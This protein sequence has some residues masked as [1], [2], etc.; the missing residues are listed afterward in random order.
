MYINLQSQIYCKFAYI[1]LFFIVQKYYIYFWLLPRA[2]FLCVML[3]K[4]NKEVPWMLALFI[5]HNNKAH[6][7]VCSSLLGDNRDIQY[8]LKDSFSHIY[9]TA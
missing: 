8:L 1:L 4:M 3:Q 7:I 5:L 6:K 2:L 9:N